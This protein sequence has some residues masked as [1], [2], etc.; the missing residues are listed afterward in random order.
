MQIKIVKELKI[1]IQD[2]IHLYGVYLVLG[3]FVWIGFKL[4]L[5]RRAS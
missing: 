3:I 4:F 5:D 2:D 1:V